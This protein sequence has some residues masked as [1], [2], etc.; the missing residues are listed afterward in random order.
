MPGY[1]FFFSNT[2]TSF[3]I[4]A[5]KPY[6]CVQ[7]IGLNYLVLGYLVVPVERAGLE[8]TEEEEAEVVA[9]AGEEVEAEL[10]EAELG[11]GPAKMGGARMNEAITGGVDIQRLSFLFAYTRITRTESKLN[12]L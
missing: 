8:K 11:K 5:L 3:G 7:N 6:R 12:S 2:S 9:V 10:K 4:R 1:K